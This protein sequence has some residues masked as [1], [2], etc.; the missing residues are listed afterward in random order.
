MRFFRS[1]RDLFAVLAAAATCVCASG[2]SGAPAT[3]HTAFIALS[4]E[5]D[6]FRKCEKSARAALES[7]GW[8]VTSAILD[9]KG[10]ATAPPNAAVIAIG[11][12]A[13]TW[14]KAQA[15]SGVNSVFCMVADPDG[16]GLL[17][18]PPLAGV[19]TEIPVARQV[20]LLR[21]ALPQARVIGLLYKRG[22][23]RGER[24]VSALKAAA[25]SAG[26]S[27]T[28]VAVE[29]K[30]EMGPALEH[31]LKN[32]VDVYWTMADGALY[33]ANTIKAV[34]SAALEAR[35]PVFGFSTAIVKAGAVVGVGIA[36]ETQGK[37]AATLLQRRAGGD[38]LK[39]ETID[40]EFEVHVNQAAADRLG[41]KLPSDL[42]TRKGE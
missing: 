37:Q 14:S 42:T 40:P 19:L 23:T 6:A 13:A 29:N 12:E 2:G 22:S 26:F 24:T 8:T 31:M 36:P 15:Q 39:A 32:G 25:D 1:T 35:V 33:D 3:P 20:A 38:A 17:T 5:A 41:I 27:V 34:L 30:D 18:G 11:T 7:Q 28:A 4:K 16:A 9:D 21:S 10:Q